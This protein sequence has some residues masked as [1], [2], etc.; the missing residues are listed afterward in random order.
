MDEQSTAAHAR[1]TAVGRVDGQR[2]RL[3]LKIYAAYDSWV[4]GQ[5]AACHAG[6]ATCCTQSVTMSAL[7]GE[8]LLAFVARQGIPVPETMT[9]QATIAAPVTTTN[10]FAAACLNGEEEK[11]PSMAG[12]WN[13][14]PCLFLAA[15][16]CLVYPARPFVCRSFMST[17]V[18][19][20]TGHAVTPPSVVTVN[21]LFM[22]IIEHL[23]QGRYWG[24]MNALLGWLLTSGSQRAGE[25]GNPSGLA[26]AQP[27]PGFLVPPED[28]PVV[29]AVLAELAAVGVSLEQ[30]LQVGSGMRHV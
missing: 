27:V 10:Q 17:V 13:Y 22:Q 25:A 1:T 30:I 7:E 19:A 4:A 8:H 21:S 18:C 26:T 6:C 29:E 5:P 12:E 28:Q 14:A 16:R 2:L 23:D 24:L 3:L 20:R 15:G 9:G 11:D